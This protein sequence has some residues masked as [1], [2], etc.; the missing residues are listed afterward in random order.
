LSLLVNF[1]AAHR[2]GKLIAT[3]VPEQSMK[4]AKK[5]NSFIEKMLELKMVE[6]T[7]K[8]TKRSRASLTLKFLPA[9]KNLPAPSL[10]FRCIFSKP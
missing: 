7:Q 8:A 3:A 4:Q 2:N 6:W 10:S 1:V 5:R 9:R